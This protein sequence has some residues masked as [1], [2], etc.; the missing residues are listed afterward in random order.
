MPEGNLTACGTDYFS[1]D[2][3]SMSYLVFYGIWVYFAPLGLII[4][5][6]WFIIQAVS[7]HEKNMREQAKKMNVA[8]LRSS[9]NANAS[10]EAKL[11]KVSTYWDG[12]PL[13]SCI[14][15]RFNDSRLLS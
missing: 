8:S 5:S 12:T 15:E 9:D 13:R 2:I 10:A 14:M 3:L 7:A 6:Y 11:A 4:Y 1:Q